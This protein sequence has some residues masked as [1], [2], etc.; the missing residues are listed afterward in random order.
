ML[1]LIYKILGIDAA[2]SNVPDRVRAAIAEQQDAAERL[3]A[4]IQFGIVVIFGFLYAITPKTSDIDPWMTPVGM[5]LAAYFAFSVLRIW[6]AYRVRLPGWFL[7]LSVIADLTLLMM[8]IWSFHIQYDQPASFYLKAPTLLYV[9]IFIALRA[10]RFE[11]RFVLLAGLASAVGWLLL[12]GYVITIDPR[13]NMITRDYVAYM[14]SNTVLLGAEF[15]K[16]ISILMVTGILSVALVRARKLLERSVIEATA[17][18]DLARFFSPEIASKI[19]H[20]DQQIR[21]GQ[22]EA[23]EAAILNVDI[24]GFTIMAN[25][26]DPS[27]LIQLLY[28][29][30]SRMV[31]IIQAHGGNIDKFLG[32]GILAT[33][34]AVLPTDAYAADAMRTVD[35]LLDAADAWNADRAAIGR[36]PISIGMA[37]VTGRI[38]FG[39][40]GDDTRLEYT[41][42][43]DPV[44][45][46]AKLEK[47][48][49]TARTRALATYEAVELAKRQGYVP[50]GIPE[51]Q[52]SAAIEGVTSGVDLVVLA[53]R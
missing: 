13:D 9:F 10:L 48:N 34:G 17:A 53:K 12:V 25:D 20:S 29:Y 27:D 23:R 21:P 15:D 38:I 14:T 6:L 28:D 40:V 52:Q 4:W 22:G 19:T 11:A 31:P 2:S 46:C 8:L 37:V 51:R 47:H 42:I 39:A 24:R 43:G 16:V 36:S 30:E 5:S 50:S 3:I 41:V 45:L 49:R 35:A 33:F 1:P 26:M 18:A 7:S 32:D 44:N